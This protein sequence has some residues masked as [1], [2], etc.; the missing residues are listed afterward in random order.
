MQLFTL[1]SGLCCLVAVTASPIQKRAFPNPEPCSG[2]CTWIHDPSVIQKDGTYYRF[3]TSGNIAIAT[4]PSMTGPWTYKGALLEHGTSIYVV[5]G[6]D[7]WAPDV[8]KVDETFY[9]YYAVSKMGIQT[10][11]IGVATSTTLDPG[12]WTDHGS[13]GLPKSAEY[14]LID[15]N[16]FKESDNSPIYLTFGSY[17]NDIFQTTLNDSPIKFSGITPKNIVS[18]STINAAV[19]EGSYQFKWQNYYYVFYSAGACCNTPPNLAKPG[20]EYRVIV[21]R[22]DSITGPFVDQSGKDCLTQSGGTL[23]LGSHDDVYAPGG[24]GVM[25]DPD[26]KSPVI[27]Y[28]YVKPSVGYNADQFFFGFNYLDFSSGWPVVV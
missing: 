4:A 9:A 23:V 13:L 10:S 19:A 20:D 14:N 1:L 28:H 26:M 16:L 15:P 7:I 18:N 25:Y 24:Q 8:F 17:W 22:S 3:S 6:Q 5:D 11:D 21:C 27:Y 2:N 12:S